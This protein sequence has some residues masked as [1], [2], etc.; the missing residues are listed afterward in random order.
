MTSP[1]QIA[2]DS[3]TQTAYATADAIALDWG[4]SQSAEQI[5]T[6]QF[7]D[8]EIPEGSVDGSNATFSLL[9]APSPAAS[10]QVTRN[11][12]TLRAGSDYSLVDR[13]VEFVS[14]AVPQPGDILQAWYR[15]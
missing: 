1:A 15:S 10:L 4:L 7:R 6:R 12:L 2:Y 13:V 5:P 9:A 11:G 8:A 14:A 3:A